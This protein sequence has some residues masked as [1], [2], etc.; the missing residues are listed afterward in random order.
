MIFF[1]TRPTKSGQL[2][3]GGSVH[4]ELTEVCDADMPIKSDAAVVDEIPLS[5]V[6]LLL[7]VIP[8]AL[9]HIYNYIFTSSEFPRQ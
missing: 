1:I 3:V 8:L 4:R 9:T 2:I 6:R 7:P 5:F